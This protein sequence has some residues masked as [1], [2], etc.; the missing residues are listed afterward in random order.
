MSMQSMRIAVATEDRTTVCDH[1]A[2]S[3]AFFVLEIDGGRIIARTV[4]ERS[5]GACGNHATFVELLEGCDAVL[6]GGIGQGAWD[7]LT[8]HGII[9]VV[10]A[11]KHSIDDAVQLYLAGKLPTTTQRTCLCG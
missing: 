4:R 10:A 5:S 3:A 2:H 1:L 7:S 9:P 6:C 8:T 11:G